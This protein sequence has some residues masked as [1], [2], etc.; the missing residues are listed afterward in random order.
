M[1]NRVKAP[2]TTP[3]TGKIIKNSLDATKWRIKLCI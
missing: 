1:L 3:R 2:D